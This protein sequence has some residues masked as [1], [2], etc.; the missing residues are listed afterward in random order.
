MIINTTATAEIASEYSVSGPE[1]MLYMYYLID[2][3]TLWYR[4]YYHLYLLI[5]KKK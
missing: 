5:K 4:N 3:L 2:S 1:E